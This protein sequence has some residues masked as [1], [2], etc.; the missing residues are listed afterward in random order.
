MLAFLGPLLAK[1]VGGIAIKWLLL[2]AVVLG[3]AGGLYFGAR[4]ITN[5][6]ETLA[7]EKATNRQR[8]QQ[9]EEADR[10]NALARET[11]AR[12]AEAQRAALKR[13]HDAALKR[14]ESLTKIKES[15][16]NATREDR[17]RPVGP[18]LRSVINGLWAEPTPPAN[19]DG[20]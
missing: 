19:G 9:L 8:I 15:I 10:A 5:T 16:A 11:A 2:G 4:H 3:L 6:I 12:E 13:E 18:V 1:K 20:H 14:I 17:D 7:A